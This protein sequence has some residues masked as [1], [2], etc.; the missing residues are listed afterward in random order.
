MKKTTRLFLIRHATTDLN[1]SERY[2]GKTNLS[3]STEGVLQAKHLKEYL[4]AFPIDV[5]ITSSSKRAKETSKILSGEKGITIKEQA[6]LNEIDFGAWEGL[7]NKEIKRNYP[8]ELSNWNKN[9]LVNE[10]PGGDSMKAVLERI[11]LV[12]KAI[13]KEYKG[14]TVALVCHGGSLNILLC[15][16]FH[17]SIKATWQFRLS[18]ASLTEILIDQDNHIVMTLCNDTCHLKEAR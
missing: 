8:K 17:I 10:I 14:K 18:P 7:T 15:Y 6:G 16:L 3:L 11:V 2:Q 4:N 5:I 1:I 13:I 12:Y 9:P